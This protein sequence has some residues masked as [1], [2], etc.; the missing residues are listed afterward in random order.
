MEVQTHKRQDRPIGCLICGAPILYHAQSAV[1]SCE[2][3]GK[4][5]E[6]NA[7][8]EAGHYVCD[9]CH[10]S[11]QADF[12]K[13]LQDSDEK[14]PIKLFAQVAVLE[15]VHMH[16]PEHHSVVPCIMLTAY[17]NNGGELDLDSALKT[18]VQRGAQVPG[19][20]CGFWGACG[21]AIGAGIYASILTGSNPL[22]SEVWALPQRLTARCLENMAR[23]G[24]PRCCKRTSR[25]AIE[26]AVRFTKEQ[27]NIEMPVGTLP[28]DY[29][30]LNQECLHSRC[31]YYGGPA[32]A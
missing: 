25:I 20:I 1:Y 22:N 18:A 19:G 16:G 23:I 21:A 10:A 13:L 24:G 4:G 27:F 3:C 28:C 32:H 14:D 15:S 11:A 31:P 30:S 2:L 12:L 6:S 8:C 26:A 7:A 17:R 9:Q 29:H 5:Y